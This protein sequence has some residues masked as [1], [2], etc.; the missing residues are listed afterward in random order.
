MDEEVESPGASHL[1]G[2]KYLRSSLE[3][4]CIGNSLVSNLLPQ[5]TDA[6]DPWGVLVNYLSQ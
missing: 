5:L 3:A 1:G 4:S 6:R 2:C